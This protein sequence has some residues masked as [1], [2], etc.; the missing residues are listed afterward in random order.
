MLGRRG[1]AQAAFT[2]A[3]LRELGHMDGVELRVGD[4]GSIRSRRRGWTRRARSPRARTSQLLREF[5]ARP[6]DPG[7]GRRVELRFLRSPVEIRGAG[8]VE[9][10]DVRRNEIV[11]EDG[12]ALRARAVDEPVETIEAGLVLRS[13]GYRAVPLPDV[14]F[15]ERAFILP[16]ERGRVLSVGRRGAPRRL[17]GRLDQARADRDPR[18][19]Q[20][21]RAGDHRLPGR[22]PARAPRARAARPRA[23][24]RAAGRAR[25]GPRHRRRL[26]R[27]RRR[28][29]RGRP[30]R[31]PPAGQAGVARRA[32]RGRALAAERTSTAA[33][34][35]GGEVGRGPR[36]LA[37]LPRY[38]RQNRQAAVD[39]ELWSHIDQN[40]PRTTDDAG[41]LAPL[42]SRS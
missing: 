3:E 11:R 35:G 41:A 14:P 9:A 24:R 7:A 23:D 19:Q 27:D 1:P 40:S 6:A 38:A 28:R 36:S 21:R 26:A 42:P 20:A 15:D 31:R 29:A 12:G 17:R 13:V 4:V 22:G 32:A 18:H 34:Y 33:G 2:S 5:A 39:G 16:N 25:A 37:R 8:R 10:I 30:Q